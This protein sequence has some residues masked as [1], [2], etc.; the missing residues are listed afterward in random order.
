MT[1]QQ[2]DAQGFIVLFNEKSIEEITYR[3]YL[4][5]YGDVDG[6]G[7]S[8]IL[9]TRE[10]EEQCYLGPNGKY[11]VRARYFNCNNKSSLVEGFDSEEEAELFI[12]E[13]LEWYIQEK[14]WDAPI[15]CATYQ[16]AI[17]EMANG[18]DRD[19]AVI[20]RYLSISKITATRQAAERLEFQIKDRARKDAI[21]ILIPIEAAAIEIDN[22]F[23]VDMQMAAKMSGNEKSNYCRNSFSLL[24]ERN[25]IT[26]I[27]SDF[28]RVFRILKSKAEKL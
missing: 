8:Q 22:R 11:E 12:Y 3:E 28:W 21:E 7:G 6:S 10:I 23:I 13:R 2:L 15:F 1:Q 24:L 16:D 25:N 26:G 18:L 9:F 14:N 17:T 20:T 19:E 5:T 4:N 27:N